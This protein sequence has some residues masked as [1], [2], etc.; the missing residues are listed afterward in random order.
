LETK[1]VL[2]SGDSQ[3]PAMK[4]LVESGKAHDYFIKGEPLDKLGRKISSLLGGGA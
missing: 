1:I 4:T 2:I 3:G